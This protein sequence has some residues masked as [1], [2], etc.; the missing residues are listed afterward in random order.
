MPIYE[1]RCTKC[2]FVTEK[3]VQLNSA[4]E[5]EF[6]TIV[7]PCP[8]CKNNTF[9]KIMSSTSFRLKGGGWFDQGYQKKED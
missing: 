4:D 3:I 7:E 5:E 9:D 8:N 6:T 1:Y 2:D